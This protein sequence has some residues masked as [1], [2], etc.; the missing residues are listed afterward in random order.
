MSESRNGATENVPAGPGDQR[1]TPILAKEILS[2]RAVLPDL[3]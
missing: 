3:P 2:A 1:L